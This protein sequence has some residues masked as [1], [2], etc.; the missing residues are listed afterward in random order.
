MAF[1]QDPALEADPGADWRDER[2]RVNGA[3]AGLGRLD[4]RER[5]A[6]RVASATRSAFGARAVASESNCP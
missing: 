4:E 6:D 1:H 5:H 2:A 3:P